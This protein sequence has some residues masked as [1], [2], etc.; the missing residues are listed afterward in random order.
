MACATCQ[1]GSP[2][3]C[4]NHGHCSTG[5]CNK[6]NTYDWLAGYEFDDPTGTDIIEVSFKKGARKEFFRNHPHNPAHPRDIVVVDMG[7]RL[8]YRYG[9]PHGRA[10]AAANEEA[11]GQGTIHLLSGHPDRQ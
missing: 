9:L 11:S 10:G 2:N 6:L 8:R 5:G 3:G 1:S 7:V 4:Q